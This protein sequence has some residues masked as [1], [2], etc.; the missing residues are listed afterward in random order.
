M[1]CQNS[2]IF[3]KKRLGFYEIISLK[4]FFEVGRVISFIYIMLLHSLSILSK[5]FALTFPK[6]YTNLSNS[7]EKQLGLLDSS[8]GKPFKAQIFE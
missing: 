7:E 1:H 6:R 4:G 2:A 5:L 8:N 3:T